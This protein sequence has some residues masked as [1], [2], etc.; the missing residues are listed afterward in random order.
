MVAGGHRVLPLN[1]SPDTRVLAFTLAVSL[2]TG[3]LFGLVPALRASQVGLAPALKTNT[4]GAAWAGRRSKENVIARLSSFFGFIALLLACVGLYGIM[5]Y[6]VVRRTS[7]IGIR[8]ALGAERGRIFQMVLREGMALVVVG[9][10][11]GLPVALAS[12]RLVSSLL[13][14]V[15]PSDLIAVLLSVL[16]MIAAAGLASF[17]PALRAMI[18]NP[19]VALRYE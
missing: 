10:A 14:G 17:L 2:A 3:I 4:S 1:V 9:I 6:S 5:S 11:L 15:S 8:M 12:S 7:E 18:A 19:M 16:L 13:Y